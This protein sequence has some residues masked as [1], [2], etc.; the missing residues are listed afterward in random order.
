MANTDKTWTEAQIDRHLHLWEHRHGPDSPEAGIVRQ[1]RAEAQKAQGW[2]PIS[3]A[4]RDGTKIMVISVVD[5]V[6]YAPDVAWFDEASGRFE[7]GEDY[8]SWPLTYWMPNTALP[9][10][11][12]DTP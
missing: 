6:W 10:H 7:N 11:T 5:G 8:L 2:R 3:T 9:Y 4:P 12:G 1:L